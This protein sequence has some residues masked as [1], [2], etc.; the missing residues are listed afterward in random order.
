MALIGEGIGDIIS[1]VTGLIS[2]EFNMTD[3]LI[4]KG[5]SLAITVCTLGVGSYLGGAAKESVK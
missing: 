2:G 5:I 1:G 4:G 3:Y